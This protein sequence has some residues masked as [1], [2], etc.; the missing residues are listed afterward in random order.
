MQILE[1]KG[2]KKYFPVTSGVFLRAKGNIHAV[3]GV[4]FSVSKGETLGIVGESGCGKTTLGRCIMGLYPLT[5]GKITLDNISLAQMSSSERKTFST[6]VQMI[7][8]DPFESL[9]PRQTVRQILEEKYLIHGQKGSNV[10][11][12]VQALLDQVGLGSEALEKY[13]HEFS[14]G[15]RQRIGI[16]RAVSMTPEII[17][18][19]EPVSALDVSVQSKIL[20]LLLDLQKNLKLT[21]LFISHDLSVVRHMSDRI[22]VMYLGKIME[23]ADA[24]TLYTSPSHPYTRALLESIPVPD[25]EIRTQKVPLKGEI[26]SVEHPP[27]GCRFNT[28]CPKAFDLCFEQEPELVTDLDNPDHKAACHL[29][30]P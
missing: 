20:N 27:Q 5:Q 24:H 16:A 17:V 14:G 11:T 4:S 21:Y 15:Q 19:D 7:F 18:C 22:L 2:L 3:D 29:F 9:D 28:R 25:P 8:Q 26:P 10:S 13:P 30:T 23:I 1:I 6:R 12:Q